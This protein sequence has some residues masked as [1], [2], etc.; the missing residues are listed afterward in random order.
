MNISSS[1][2]AMARDKESLVAEYVLGLAEV[3]KDLAF[4]VE[5][6]REYAAVRADCVSFPKSEDEKFNMVFDAMVVLA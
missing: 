2:A 1:A 3:P 4:L 5:K 6:Y